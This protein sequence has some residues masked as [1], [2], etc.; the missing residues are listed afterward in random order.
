MK[1]TDIKQVWILVSKSEMVTLAF[2]YSSQETE[3]GV[4]WV[5]TK[6]GLQNRTL[7]V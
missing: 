3:E 1:I 7:P 2:N 5:Q 4:L 6:F